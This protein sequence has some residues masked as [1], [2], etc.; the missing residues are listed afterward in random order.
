[1]KEEEIN[2]SRVT[3][4][5]SRRD[6]LVLMGSGA[7]SLVFGGWKIPGHPEYTA[8]VAVQ[9]YSVRREIIT[10]F[11]NNIRKLANIGFKGVETY[12]LPSNITLARAAKAFRKHGLKVISMHTE[13]PGGRETENILRS[14]E[15]YGCSYVVY[16]GWPKDEKYKDLEGIKRMAGVYNKAGS[17]L[18]SK[19]LHFGLHN[20]WWEF[21]LVDGVYPFYY[22]LENLDP[23]IFFEIDAYWARTGGMDPVKIVKEFGARAPFLHVK[24][25]PA[26]EGEKSYEQV[27][28][29]SGVMDYKSIAKAGGRNIKWMIVEFDEFNGSIYNALQDSYNYLVKTKLAKG[30]K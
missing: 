22:L 13:L 10:D 11:E 12:A 20:H 24:D 27:P 7:A 15:A 6:F 17:F 5:Y 19:G 29:G 21:Q 30:K 26:V 2:I 3:G 1:M 9:L 25:G 14:A 23:E 18:R 4:A 28:A 8:P 16:P